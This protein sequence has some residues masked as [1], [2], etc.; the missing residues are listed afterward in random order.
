MKNVKII[1]DPRKTLLENAVHYREEAKKFRAK[2]EGAERAL[3]ETLKAAEQ[4]AVEK[5]QEKKRSKREWFAIFHHFKTSSGSLVIGGRNAKQNDLIYSRHASKGEWFLHA[6]IRGSPAVIVKNPAATSEELEE[7]AQFTASYSSAW[8]REF[9]SVDVYAVRCEQVSKHFQGGYLDQGG[10]AISGERTWF[11]NTLLG[12]YICI[13][14]KDLSFLVKPLKTGPT[15]IYVKL[16]PGKGDK[17]VVSKAI[18]AYFAKKL[19]SQGVK[20]KL[21]LDEIAKLIP[22]ESE[23]VIEE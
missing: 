7:A 4:Q 9:G 6:D 1:L 12:L 20:T 16:L 23:L 14:T 2:S 21:D 17:Q 3:A 11:K 10:F 22:G 18:K 5:T 8:K 19:F 15:G 13:D